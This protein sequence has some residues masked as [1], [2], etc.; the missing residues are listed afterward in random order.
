MAAPTRAALEAWLDGYVRLWNAGDHDAWLENHRKLVS[1]EVTMEDPVG[2][3]VKRGVEACF[4]EPWRRFNASTKFHLRDVFICG[5]E[6]AFVN[7]NHWSHGGRTTIGTSIEIY[8]FRP[9]GSLA[10]RTWW[11]MPDL[12]VMKEYAS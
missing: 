7:D 1:G 3:N 10:I 11:E 5:S 8:S 9:D 4:E 2:T 12:P 6:V